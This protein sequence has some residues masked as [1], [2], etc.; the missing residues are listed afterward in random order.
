MREILFR[1][2]RVDNGEWVEGQY[3]CE[4]YEPHLQKVLHIDRIAIAGACVSV[5][6]IPET[7][8]QYTGLKD[9]NGTRIFEG[10]ICHFYG[11]EYYRGYW[12]ANHVCEIKIHHECLWYIENAEHVEVIGN[13]HDNPE[14]LKGE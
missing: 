5:G 6:V 9:E 11:G 1:G 12:E 13:I 4:E 10:D 14:L 3:T 8:G 7:V 2:K